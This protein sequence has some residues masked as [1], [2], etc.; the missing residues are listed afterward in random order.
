[1]PPPDRR[2]QRALDPDQ[3][4]PERLHRLVGQPVAG[5]VERLL[6]GQHLLP[7]DLVAVLGGGGVEDQLGGGPDVDAGAVALDEG[8]D[9]LVGDDQV[10]VVAHADE[11]CHV[12]MLRAGAGT[13]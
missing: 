6:P 13:D 4:L 12:R 7:G 8:D 5:L 1:M 11:I 10:A 2:G 9:G 3:V